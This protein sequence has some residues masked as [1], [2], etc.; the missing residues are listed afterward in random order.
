MNTQPSDTPR[1]DEAEDSVRSLLCDD[2]VLSGYYDRLTDLCRKLERENAQLR[3]IIKEN[4]S[5]IAEQ[6]EALGI[7]SALRA[8]LAEAKANE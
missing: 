4:I 5:T 2:S 7:A 6:A 1:T 8:Q 3:E